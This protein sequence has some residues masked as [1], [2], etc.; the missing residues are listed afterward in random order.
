VP[1]VDAFTLQLVKEKSLLHEWS[2]IAA[3]N[4]EA[5]L[6][7][8]LEA[9]KGAPSWSGWT[10]EWGAYAVWEKSFQRRIY[11]GWLAG[12]VGL[13]QV[14]R[15]ALPCPLSLHRWSSS[16]TGLLRKPEGTASSRVVQPGLVFGLLLYQ[17]WHLGQWR[18][19]TSQTQSC[20]SGTRFYVF[21]SLPST[22]YWYF[23]G[24]SSASARFLT[25]RGISSQIQ[26]C[27]ATRR[28]LPAF[29][30]S[31]QGELKL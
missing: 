7:S 26:S 3:R 31:Y 2:R 30:W 6:M 25:Y 17:S 20:M 24:S 1:E 28:A 5:R 14:E 11:S 10:Q 29:F 16:I 23:Q 13:V 21:S 12:R 18:V 8:H 22:S 19:L 9:L 4:D 27:H 15:S